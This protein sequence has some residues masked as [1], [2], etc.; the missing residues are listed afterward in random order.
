M[1]SSE[2]LHTE[3]YH[4]ITSRDNEP[5]NAEE[6]KLGESTLYITVFDHKERTTRIYTRYDEINIFY[7]TKLDAPLVDVAH[8]L[9]E[10]EIDAEN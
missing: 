3:D 1:E 8:F 7:S 2:S 5:E 9:L 6:H 4:R 10:V